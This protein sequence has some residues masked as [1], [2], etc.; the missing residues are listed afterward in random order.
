[1]G[2]CTSQKYVICED[3]SRVCAD[4]TVLAELEACQFRN[5]SPEETAEYMRPLLQKHLPLSQNSSRSS[6]L[7]EERKRDHY[8]HWTLRLAFSATE[9]L[10]KRFARLETTLFKMRLYADD[11]R[12]RR[13]FIDSLNMSWD[14]V[15]DQDKADYGDQLRAATGW[16]KGE[17]ENWFQVDWERVP[18]LVEHRRVLLRKGKAFVHVREQ[19]SMV[20]GEFGRQ[21]EA[22][23]TLASR[24]L[25]RMDEDDRLSPILTHLAKSFAAPEA[26]YSEEASSITGSVNPTAAAIDSLSKFFP[27][28]MQNLHRELRKQSHLK[29]FARLQ[30]TL[31]LKGIGMD[32]QQCIE[33]WSR[34][35]KLITEGGVAA[36]AMESNADEYRQIQKG[37]P[38]QYQARIWRGGWR[39]ESTRSRILAVQLPKAAD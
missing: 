10:R 19:V 21:L 11:V 32:M 13:D 17:E 3:C 14:T 37:I 22:G 5:R 23:L 9:D 8:S 1:M 26:T 31:F 2:Y 18:E 7:E 24:A 33:F 20:V 4:K 39:L 16:R 15:T 34:S 36:R 25:P 12:E 28:C 38:L 35:F 29:H 6:S 27:L 30:Y